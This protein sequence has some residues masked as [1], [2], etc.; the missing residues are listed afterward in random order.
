MKKLLILTAVMM[1][2]ATAGGCRMCDW[3]RRGS[4][5]PC[6][7]SAPVYSAPAYDPCASPCAS[8]CAAPGMMGP[9]PTTVIGGPGPG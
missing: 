9:G 6:Q 2:T 3:F 7:Q 1:L 8:P 5:E 4:Y